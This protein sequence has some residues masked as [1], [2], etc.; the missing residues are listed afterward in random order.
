MGSNRMYRVHALI[1]LF[2]SVVLNSACTS[3]YAALLWCLGI[4]LAFFLPTDLT[5][6][7]SGNTILRSNEVAVEWEGKVA[8]EYKDA[9]RPTDPGNVLDVLLWDRQLRGW[10]DLLPSPPVVGKENTC[11]EDVVDAPLAVLEELDLQAVDITNSDFWNAWIGCE[12]QMWELR[13]VDHVWWWTNHVRLGGTE[14][15]LEQMD[16]HVGKEKDTRDG[17]IKLTRR[18]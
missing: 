4:M 16:N 10:N 6:F 2:R 14:A 8:E 15:E 13:K 18:N 11:G 1:H 17:Q 5:I 7:L 3:R 12:E 9:N